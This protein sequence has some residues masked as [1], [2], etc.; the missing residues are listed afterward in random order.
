[1][2]EK[3]RMTFEEVFK[4]N[5][6]RIYYHMHKLRVRDP[7]REFYQEGLVAMWNAYEKYEPDRGPMA[8]YFN[9]IIRNRMIDL[10]RKKERDREGFQQMTKEMMV[11]EGNGNYCKTGGKAY[12]IPNRGEA[13]TYDGEFWR[14]IRSGLSENQWKWVRL[15]VMEGMSIKDIAEQEHVSQDAVKSWGREARKKLKQQLESQSDYSD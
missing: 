4:Q 8:T 10:I 1:M 14:K 5:E 12:P 9:Y 7:E 2:T 13:P 11:R 3:K 15:F 6:R